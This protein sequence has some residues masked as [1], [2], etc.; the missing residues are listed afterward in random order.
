MRK[1]A[2]VH[3]NTGV[4]QGCPLSPLLFSLYVNDIDEHAEGV[5]GAVTGT[6]GVHVTHILYADDCTLTANNPN[7]LKNML[8]CLG[9]KRKRKQKSLRKPKAACIKERSLN[10]QASKGLTKE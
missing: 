9:F 8:N 3:P 10:K 1:T 2:R 7:A 4:K 6:D 5:Q